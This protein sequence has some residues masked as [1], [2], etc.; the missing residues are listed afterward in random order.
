MPVC[1]CGCSRVVTRL[2]APGHDMTYKAMLREA[3]EAQTKMTWDGSYV[4][5][6][7]AIDRIATAIGSDWSLVPTGGKPVRRTPVSATQPAR[8]SPRRSV[9]VPDTATVPSSRRPPTPCQAQRESRR[10][11]IREERID[12]LMDRLD[13]SVRVG[14]WGWYR[15][16]SAPDTRFAARVHRTYRDSGNHATIDVFI[17]SDDAI[18]TGVA[19]SS[20]FRD[21]MARP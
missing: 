9:T 20:F 18:V 16:Q 11:S 14:H 21:D 17:P 19:V 3:H 10:R 13:T 12:S 4:T 2:F 1:P 8:T 15:P 5:V 7:D 6:D